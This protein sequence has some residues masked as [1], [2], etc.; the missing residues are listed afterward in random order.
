MRFAVRDP[1]VVCIYFAIS[2]LSCVAVNWW[3]QRSFVLP[4]CCDVDSYWII[5]ETYR[6]SGL[7]VAHEFASLRTYA[8]PTLLAL[9]LNAAE[10]IEVSPKVLLAALQTVAY[11][12][13]SFLLAG[14]VA[15]D[16][17]GRI[18]VFAILALNVYAL[19]YLAVALADSLA[20]VVFQFWVAAMLLQWRCADE[21]GARRVALVAVAGFLAGLVM[22]VRPAFV[23]VPIVTVVCVFLPMTGAR[24]R[25]WRR[26]GRAAVC[27][28]FIL[29]P[30][31]PQMAINQRH[32]GTASPMPTFELRDL[33]IRWG[34]ANLKYATLMDPARP[35]Q[36]FYPNPFYIFE[37]DQS[38][39]PVEWYGQQPLP[40]GATLLTKSV[41]AFDFD[42]VEPYIYDLAQNW[43]SE[44]RFA[45]LAILWLGIC[46]T[47]AQLI[48]RLPARF[49]VG[50][51][52][53]PLLLL[54]G[55]GAVT[56]ASVVEL[57]FSLPML[58]VFLLL[59]VNVL[60]SIST[61]GWRGITVAAATGV[62]GTTALYVIAQISRAALQL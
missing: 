11:L 19:P 53:F 25:F 43:Q 58:V 35:P 36:L 5:A 8:F 21:R 46:G 62:I 27:A 15:H 9:T 4:P 16:R 3:L 7:L 44:R 60:R 20:L 24:P 42:F 61:F 32:F 30:L 57:R 26:L 6:Q 41:A 28:I 37:E 49:C 18:F 52:V 23:W 2:A 54:I 45:S 12:G 48:R 51:T 40:A 17:R 39:T 56:L 33:Q 22:E 31:L 13:S 10:Y 50:P 38:S 14:A 34:K 47:L 55:W 29:M 1:R 59:S